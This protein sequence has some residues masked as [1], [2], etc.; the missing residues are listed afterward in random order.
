[1]DRLKVNVDFHHTIRGIKALSDEFGGEFAGYI[2]D[3]DFRVI[4]DDLLEAFFVEW[5][6]CEYPAGWSFDGS[7]VVL[8]VI[9]FIDFLSF[10]ILEKVACGVHF[11]S[12]DRKCVAGFVG[13]EQF[14]GGYAGLGVAVVINFGFFKH[15]TALASVIRHDSC[16]DGG[17]ADAGIGMVKLDAEDLVRDLG[18]VLRT[19]EGLHAHMVCEDFA[20]SGCVALDVHYLGR[21]VQGEGEVVRLSF[22]DLQ[23]IGLQLIVVGSME[24]MGFLDEGENELPA[25]VSYFTVVDGRLA[26]CGVRVVNLR[27]EDKLLSFGAL[28]GTVSSP[29]FPGQSRKLKI[30]QGVG[31]FEQQG[32]GRRTVILGVAGILARR[33]VLLRVRIR[34]KRTVSLVALRSLANFCFLWRLRSLGIRRNGIFGAGRNT[35]PNN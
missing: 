6:D 22:F 29:A 27:T 2:N 20:A 7:G 18:A 32:C 26:D 17:L 10:V 35:F 34:G 21:L 9:V 25:V 16:V 33:H 4:L 14:A 19:D 13:V 28:F 3:I 15:E 1:V 8:D 12:D 11:A 24:K 23:G 30:L 5:E 31:A